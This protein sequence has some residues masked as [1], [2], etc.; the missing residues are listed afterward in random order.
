MPAN[1]AI[2]AGIASPGAVPTVMTSPDLITW[3]PVTSWP[4]T[5]S[6]DVNI[7]GNTYFVATDAPGAPDNYAHST[8]GVTW[9]LGSSSAS[10]RAVAWDGTRFVSRAPT[11]RAHTATSAAGPWTAAGLLGTNN[12]PRRIIHELG[13]LIAVGSGSAADRAIVWSSDGGTTWSGYTPTNNVGA[14]DIEFAAGRFVAVRPRFGAFSDSVMTSTV[15]TSWSL[16]TTGVTD[17]GWYQVA[18]GNGTF[19]VIGED[20]TAVGAA[21]TRVMRSA[22]GVTGW[23]GATP[24]GGVRFNSLSRLTFWN[25][26]FAVVT[27][28]FPTIWTSPDG[29]AWTGQTFTGVDWSDIGAGPA[30]T[31]RL[32]GYRGIGLVRGS[33]G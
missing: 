23:V 31:P 27:P 9:T 13:L 2:V 6:T 19:L 4:G 10:M 17:K 7:T 11:T 26:L 25:G 29:L 22:D 12:D 8:D 5:G 33:R 1:L 24:T 30:I 32:G 16:V 3:T 20:G 28:G 18:Y 14:Y 21:A 15:G